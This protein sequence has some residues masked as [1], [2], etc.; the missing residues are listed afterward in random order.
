[1]NRTSAAASSS[2][3]GIGFGAMGTEASGTLRLAIPIMIGNLGQMLMGLC[4]TIMVGQIPGNGAVALAACGFA[5]TI[6]S[7]FFVFGF[8]LLSGVSVVA[9]QGFGA[10]RPSV[11]AGAWH[12]GL[13]MAALAGLFFGASVHLGID[14]AHAFGQPQEV[15]LSA[16]G[17]LVIV[18]WSMLPAFVTSVGKS[19]SEALSRPWIPFW[20]MMGGVGLN[21]FLNWLWIFGHWGFPAMGLDGAAWAT[22]VSRV[23]VAIGTMAYVWG[24]ALFR[25]YRPL[26]RCWS[27]PRPSEMAALFMIGFPIAFQLLGEVAA[28]G[29]GSI[30]MG[31]WGVQAL[32]AHQIAITCAATTFMVPLGLSSATTIRMGQAFGERHW[33]RLRPIAASSWV[34]SMAIMSFFGIMF[35]FFGRTIAGQFTDDPTTL[36][37]TAQLLVVAAVFQVF[38]GTQ[39]VGVGALRGINDVR[40]PTAIVLVA[41][42]IISLP[43]GYWLSF[44]GGMGPA[45]IWIGLMIGLALVSI[46]FAIRLWFK[47]DP[48]STPAFTPK[49]KTL[50][51]G[52]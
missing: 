1:M 37:L 19:V 31:W 4:D 21:I 34:L 47:T 15:V 41:Y 30:M 8:G 18:G 25:P 28:F 24:A 3:F 29:M 7:W 33:N 14:A 36:L 40:V 52:S 9:S 22:W 38:D 45:G 16:T 23:L 26:V 39:V 2:S 50:V 35:A 13:W 11:V 32:V 43:A 48:T 20:I 49:D 44:H 46:L 5:N 6:L 10:Q 27:V 17:Y 42:W 12:G 51:C